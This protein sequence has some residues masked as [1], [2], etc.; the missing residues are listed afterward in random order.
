MAIYVLLVGKDPSF[1]NFELLKNRRRHHTS[2]YPTRTEN[3]PSW[4]PRRAVTIS[5]PPSCCLDE[6]P[7]RRTTG[8]CRYERKIKIKTLF[9]EMRGGKKKTSYTHT[10]TSFR[11][12]SFCPSSLPEERPSG[13]SRYDCAS[14]LQGCYT[15]YIYIYILRLLSI[16]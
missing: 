12:E 15:H 4:Q 10:H 6:D 8:S 13:N 14:S 3:D 9:E 1:R 16:R 2:S 11:G 7:L 5:I